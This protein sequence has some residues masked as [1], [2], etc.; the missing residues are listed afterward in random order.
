M[1]AKAKRR[2]DFAKLSW[3]KKSLGAPEKRY[4]KNGQVLRLVRYTD[5]FSEAE[6]CAKGHVGMVLSGRMVIE[7]GNE[8]VEYNAGDAL[9]INAGDRDKHKAVIAPGEEATVLLF[10]DP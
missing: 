6:W 8:K 7:F 3:R 10:E 9:F 1:A 4:A 2:I 5:E